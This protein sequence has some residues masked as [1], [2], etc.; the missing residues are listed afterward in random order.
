MSQCIGLLLAAG[1]GLRMGKP[2]AMVAGADGTP[3]VIS[4]SI[5]LRSGGCDEVVVV[6]GADADVVREQLSGQE[7]TVVEAADWADGMSVSLK[8]GLEAITGRQAESALIHLV[9]LPDVGP[10]VVKRLLTE[11]AADA[12]AR[13]TYDDRL[14]HPVLIGREHWRAVAA[15]AAGD[16]GARE[17]LSSR[18]V[19]KIECADLATGRDVDS[20]SSLMETSDDLRRTQ[21]DTGFVHRS[22]GGGI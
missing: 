22:A 7:V 16:Y 15:G 11:S 20:M 18:D 1:A 14:G 21:R 9:D 5:T 17:Y 10:E 4:S 12:L 13:A 8:A 6:V 2:K 19:V 3:W